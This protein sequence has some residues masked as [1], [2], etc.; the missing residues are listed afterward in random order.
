[1]P[2]EYLTVD[3]NGYNQKDKDRAHV[4]ATTTELTLQPN[5][6]ARNRSIVITAIK[7]LFENNSTETG[8]NPEILKNLLGI[9]KYINESNERDYNL[10]VEIKTQV[11]EEATKLLGNKKE[12]G[13][14][15]LEKLAATYFEA[16]KNNTKQV[17][18]LP[19]ELDVKYESLIVDDPRVNHKNIARSE[20]KKILTEM[21]NEHILDASI[22]ETLNSSNDKVAKQNAT[23]YANY[24]SSMQNSQGE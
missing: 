5:I 19:K 17:R 23:D 9:E 2:Y 3:T 22:L 12:L 10:Y 8:L 7:T 16:W 6:L 24:L 20:V 4:F 11:K 18:D 14:E 15:D 21:V 13:F 1:M